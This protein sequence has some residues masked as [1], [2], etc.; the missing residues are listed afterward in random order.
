MK[1]LIK[2][3]PFLPRTKDTGILILAVIF[4]LFVPP[5]VGIIIGALLGV[6][7][8]LLPLASVVGMVVSAYTIM[9]IIFAIMSY[10]GKEIE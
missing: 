2:F 3:F 4:Y 5:I 6:T 7:I 10:Q 9:G 1:T 8:I